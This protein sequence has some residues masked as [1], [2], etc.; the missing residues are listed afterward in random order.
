MRRDR[1][2]WRRGAGAG[3]SRARSEARGLGRRGGGQCGEQ[4]GATR[5]VGRG[6]PG[7]GAVPRAS[8]PRRGTHPRSGSRC[9]PWLR[10]LASWGAPGGAPGATPPPQPLCSAVAVSAR[11]RTARP[12][13][14][15][16]RRRRRRRPAPPPRL[17]TRRRGGGGPGIGCARRLPAPAPRSRGALPAHS[18]ARLGGAP[19]GDRDPR[20]GLFRQGWGL[21]VPAAVPYLSPYAS[22]SPS[23]QTETPRLRPEVHRRLLPL[24]FGS[25]GLVL[26]MGWGCLEESGMGGGDASWS[27]GLE[28]HIPSVLAVG[29]ANETPRL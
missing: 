21:L 6:A 12:L 25:G 5:R 20:L 15:S 2:A 18:A 28:N 7:C 29:A 8:P 1:R 3:A 14:P 23:V 17:G 24:P 27:Q 9:S 16:R 19:A 13:H 22:L 26:G 11:L 10:G 4:A